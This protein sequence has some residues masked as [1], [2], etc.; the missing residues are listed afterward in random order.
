MFPLDGGFHGI[1]SL[2]T[3]HSLFLEALPSQLTHIA[4]EETS[5]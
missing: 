4:L 1:L 2:E 5:A 3:L